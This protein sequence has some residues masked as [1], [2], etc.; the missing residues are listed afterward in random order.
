MIIQ[1][2]KE[3]KKKKNMKKT[4]KQ[5]TDTVAGMLLSQ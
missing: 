3:T 4:Q 1:R 5:T 2:N